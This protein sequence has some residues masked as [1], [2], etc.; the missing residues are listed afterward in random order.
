MVSGR[1]RHREARQVTHLGGN[2]DAVDRGSVVRQIGPAQ[3]QYS[4]RLGVDLDLESL[5]RG[6]NNP[7]RAASAFDRWPLAGE[8]GGLPRVEARVEDRLEGGVDM[9][10]AEHLARE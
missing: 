6:G 9:R 5:W 2:R 1:N 4:V 8:D 10:S 3:N 7:R